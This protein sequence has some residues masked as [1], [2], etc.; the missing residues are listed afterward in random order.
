MPTQTD[1][2]KTEKNPA[3]DAMFNVGAHYGFIKSRRHP[4]IKSFIFGVK[5]KV[6][7]FDLDKTEAQLNTAL[8]F[9]KSV[10]AS[11]KQLV[12]VGSKSEARD[13]IKNA[14]DRIAQPFVASR[15][16]GG[17]FTNF[18][19]IRKRVE[20]LLDLISQKEKGELNKYT[21]KERVMIDRDIERLTSLFGG[22][23]TMNTLPGAIFVA[24]PKKEYI[25]VAEAIAR[26]IPV[27]ALSGAD[28]DISIIK[29]PIVAND[30]S[31]AS[32]AFFTDKVAEVY[33]QGK[34]MAAASK[35]SADKVVEKAG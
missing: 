32:V 2:K 20:K 25:A 31:I 24:D 8:E 15:W 28:C 19:I 16:I 22:I 13:A 12:F 23:T 4:T 21:K 27:V 35:A 3:I 33:S 5:N 11:G 29:Y 17:T 14:A 10:A 1:S 6:E 18:E 9:I 26:K 7:I 34:A 30:S